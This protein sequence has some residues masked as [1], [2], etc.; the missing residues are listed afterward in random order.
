M[1]QQIYQF[2]KS[3][4]GTSFTIWYLFTCCVVSLPSPDANSGK[5]YTWLFTVLHMIINAAQFKKV[6]GVL[7]DPTAPV[8]TA[9]VSTVKITPGTNSPNSK[10]TA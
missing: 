8:I 9:Q 1:L 3:H 10:Y 5:F 4:P 7:P 6:Q 2:V